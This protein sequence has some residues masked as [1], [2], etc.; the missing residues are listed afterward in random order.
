MS[1]IIVLSIIIVPTKVPTCRENIARQFAVKICLTK[2]SDLT[3][4][5]G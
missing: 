5:T 3:S 2:L 4:H 1:M